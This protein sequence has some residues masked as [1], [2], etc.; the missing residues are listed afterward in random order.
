MKLP[1][2]TQRLGVQTILWGEDLADGLEATLQTIQRLGFKGVEFAQVPSKL[3]EP[4]RLEQAL[5]AHDLTLLGLAGGSTS[6]A[7]SRVGTN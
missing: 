4:E 2:W 3:G 6:A 5:R 7:I 1:D